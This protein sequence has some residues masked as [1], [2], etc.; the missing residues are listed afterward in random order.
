MNVPLAVIATPLLYNVPLT[1]IPVTVKMR[2][3]VVLSTSVTFNI[4]EVNTVAAD[5]SNTVTPVLVAR[6]GASLV[7][8]IVI[9]SV[10]VLETAAFGSLTV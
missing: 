3:A 4:A 1:G 2:C 7:P 10:A 8:V 9:V 5:P 6:I